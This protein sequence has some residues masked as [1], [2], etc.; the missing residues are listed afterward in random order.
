[1]TLKS[2]LY[3]ETRWV[4]HNAGSL[5]LVLIVLPALFA[6]ATLA[7]EQVVPRDTPVGVAPAS[8][9]VPQENVDAVVG[10]AT[11][12]SRPHTYDSPSAATR[13]LARE[14]VYA[15]FVVPPDLLEEGQ[16]STIEM[17]VAEEMVPYE[18]PSQ[19]IRSILAGNINEIIPSTQVERTVI[20]EDRS[21]SEFLVSA[22]T[23]L[24][25]MVY[26]FVLLPHVVASERDVYRRVRVS[27]SLGKLLTAKFAVFTALMLVP[28][29]GAQA[30]ASHFGLAV[31]LL[32]P[33]A[34]GVT[35]LTFCYLGAIAVAVMFAFD[36]S[37][38]GRLLNVALLFGGVVFASMVYPAGFFS[39]LRRTIAKFLPMHY[40]M[41]VQRGA[42][43]KGE[44]LAMYGDYVA[45]L[46]GVTVLAVLVLAASVRYHEWRT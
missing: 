45:M 6:G 9:D 22:A 5:I 10:I 31:A 13:G 20:G 8:A 28:I 11:L 33:L 14:E 43:L 18:Q 23:L 25:A 19:A 2:F 21:L 3:R 34:V 15:V 41:I 37:T 16:S 35:L 26:A 24:L 17:I 36:F 40:S 12:F 39:P 7:F 46:V 44:G 30:I 42:A 27:S 4:R 1:M 29:A 32:D 38:F